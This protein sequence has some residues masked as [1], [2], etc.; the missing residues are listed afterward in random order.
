MMDE[1]RNG[2]L[3]KR[4]WWRKQLEETRA[5]LSALAELP[6]D[7][8]NLT[9]AKS[10]LED[11]ERRFQADVW[12]FDALIGDDDA[13]PPPGVNIDRWVPI[14][15]LVAAAEEGDRWERLLAALKEAATGVVE[16]EA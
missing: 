1:H 13:M 7:V 14:E 15:L 4:A 6:D 11:K 12:A 9:G 16:S 3:V 8:L 10:M 5:R 2:E